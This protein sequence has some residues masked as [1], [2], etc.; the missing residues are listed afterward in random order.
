MRTLAL[1]VSLAV[2]TLAAVT[3]AATPTLAQES[4]LLALHEQRREG[5]KICLVGHFHAG[6]SSGQRSKRLALKAAARDWQGF[7]A[8]E[9]GNHWGLWKNAKNKSATCQQVGNTWSCDV[10]GRPCRSARRLRR[11]RR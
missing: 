4:A 10:E 6:A 8:W 11:A 5:R 1:S 9:Y 7:T 3:A 2:A